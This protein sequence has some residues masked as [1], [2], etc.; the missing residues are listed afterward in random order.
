[1]IWPPNIYV[2]QL[3]VK[4][5]QARDGVA[6]ESAFAVRAESAGGCRQC[7]PP[8]SSSSRWPQVVV[9]VGDSLQRGCKDPLF[10]ATEQ[11]ERVLLD[12]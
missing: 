1:M 12:A 3:C 10:A 6:L 8:L 7:V 4:A 2:W 11:S 5:E 9:M